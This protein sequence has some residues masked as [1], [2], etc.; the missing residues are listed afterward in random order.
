MN[1]RG[2]I[3]QIMTVL[4]VVVAVGVIIL[5]FWAGSTLLPILTGTGGL[6]LNQIST[7]VNTN[8][9]NTELANATNVVVTTGQGLLGIV[10]SVVY[11]VFIF[12]IIG[13][14]ILCYYVRSYPF[15]AYIWVFIMIVLVFMSMFLANAYTQAST[16][17][18]IASFYSTW[19]SNDFL[20]TNLPMILS[21]VGV[22]GGIFLFIL[23]SR[24]PESEVQQL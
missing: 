18:N 2:V 21:F 9:P 19:G 12:L 6:L 14:F 3:D 4:V 15:L 24:D 22:F 8:S 23:A 5:L 16:D 17:P 11:F 13:Y 10:E 7:S 20:M 1:R